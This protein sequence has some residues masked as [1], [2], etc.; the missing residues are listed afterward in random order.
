MAIDN[1]P[2]ELPMAASKGFADMLVA[3]V[4][5]AFFNDDANGNLQ[6]ALVTKN[7]KL[8]ERF[9]YLQGYVGFK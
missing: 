1:L 8:T 4:F 5:P 7:G 2:C 6:R 9:G 3:H